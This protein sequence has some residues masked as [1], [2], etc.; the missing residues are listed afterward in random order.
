MTDT[1]HERVCT[2]CGVLKP[3]SDFDIS[4]RGRFGRE[5]R[6]KACKSAYYYANRDHHNE[7]SKRNYRASYDQYRATAARWTKEN[8]ERAKQWKK[9][10]YQHNKA[11]IEA[12]KRAFAEEH[13]DRV[14]AWRRKEY[15]KNWHRYA[16]YRPLW[17]AKN[18]EKAHESVRRW[19][20]KNPIAN[21]IKVH[22]RRIRTQ[23][24]GPSC[25]PA[26]WAAMCAWFGNVCLCCNAAAPLTM[27]HVI[28]VVKDGTNGI[29]NMQPLCRSCNSKKGVQI[30]DYRDAAH[31]AAFLLQ[32]N[33]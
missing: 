12:K 23:Q 22:R 20:R 6:C 2:K 7:V 29:E 9:E 15:Y 13:P 1:T 16:A 25:T 30:I 28:P 5:A 3:L 19:E 10:H 21:R 14:R 32:L 4:L 17:R 18:P 27:D 11:E 24:G 31:L 33:T 26:Q 8:P